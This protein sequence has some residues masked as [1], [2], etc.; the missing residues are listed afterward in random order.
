MTAAL[1]CKKVPNLLGNERLDG[2][3]QHAAEPDRNRIGGATMADKA[4]IT[5]A[6][7]RQLLRYAPETGKLY[8]LPRPASMFKAARDWKIWN[9][10]YANA[11]ALTAPFEGYR[12]GTILGKRFTAH[13]VAWAVHYGV[14]PIAQIDHIN[15]N[16]SDNRATNLRDVANTDNRRNM[17]R[18]ANNRSGH[19][20]VSWSKHT[21]KWRSAIMVD[22]LTVV[23]GY[24]ESKDEA[25]A[26]R[27]SA[28]RQYGFHVNHGRSA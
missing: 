21:G 5:P 19:I 26:A 2:C 24:F 28:E 23:L 20:G 8:W 15:G 4:D 3:Y 10:R 12:A 27:K 25:V 17:K 6:I 7:L 18:P 11:E 14:W 16:R 13:R 9:T 1:A 22:R